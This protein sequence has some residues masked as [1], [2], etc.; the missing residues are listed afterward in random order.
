M[1]NKLF[2]VS[3][4]IPAYNEEANIKNLLESI[5]RQKEMDFVLKEIIVISDKSTDN[6]ENIVRNFRDSRVML[7]VNQKRLGKAL[8]VK[9]LI[10]LSKKN[11]SDIVV[12]LDADLRLKNIQVIEK[13]IK[14]FFSDERL[15]V[16]SGNL[17]PYFPKTFVEK[18]SSFDIQVRNDIIKNSLHNVD[19]YLCSD[20]I[21]AFKTNYI[22]VKDFD[23]QFMHDEFYFFL[24]KKKKLNFVY[25]EDA[26]AYQKLPKKINDYVNQMIRF[27]GSPSSSEKNFGK[28]FIEQYATITV[29][30][31]INSFIHISMGSPILAFAYI[32][33]Q[34]YS[35]IKFA[36]SKK[37]N[38][39]IWN[40]IASTK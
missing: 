37:N 24:A 13:L 40:P 16:T 29:K 12:I 33:I 2:S 28:K 17:I 4:G 6:T 26:K 3:V 19:Y 18:I 35:K 31:K 32:A 21:V 1:K 25:V 7:Y 5:L 8:S 38:E 9:K 36:L 20:P 14:P 11:S 34:L 10:E 23:K 22:S 15:M 27:L 30:D 39:A